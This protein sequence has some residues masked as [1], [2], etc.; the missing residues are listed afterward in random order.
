MHTFYNHYT[1]FNNIELSF[2]KRKV[3]RIE[4]I[5]QKS[6][7]ISQDLNHYIKCVLNE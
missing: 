7:K 5:R 2:P 4:N 1:N 3:K 6:Q